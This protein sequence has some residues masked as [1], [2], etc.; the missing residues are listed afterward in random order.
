M[1]NYSY[2]YT[3]VTQI[4]ED[5]IRE[6]M[7]HSQDTEVRENGFPNAGTYF[8]G[9]AQI[10]YAAWADITEGWHTEN[11]VKR[12]ELLTGLPPWVDVC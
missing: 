11:D 5:R 3:A 2:F 7:Q 10:V 4:A 1:E 6:L 8:C 9:C 12:L